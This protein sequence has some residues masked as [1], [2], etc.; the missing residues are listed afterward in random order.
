[1]FLPEFLEFVKMTSAKAA[2]F[3]EP[4]FLKD[5]REEL[6]KAANESFM[7]IK[8]IKLSKMNERGKSD[9]QPPSNI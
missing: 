8:L 7:K 6:K 5:N 3:L 2:P 4:K 1:M 9:S